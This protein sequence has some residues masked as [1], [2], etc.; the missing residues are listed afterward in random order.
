MVDVTVPGFGQSQN[1]AKCFSRF[2]GVGVA[3]EI[4]RDLGGGAKCGGGGKFHA[5]FRFRSCLTAW[6]SA[7][8]TQLM[9]TTHLPN[10]PMNECSN[11]PRLEDLCNPMPT[12]CGLPWSS[13]RAGWVLLDTL[14]R[15]QWPREQRPRV[16]GG[17]VA[18]HE[19][20]P[21]QHA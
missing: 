20:R 1:F 18:S 19:A 3:P 14:Y 16:L 6:R 12:S 11:L 13:S 10:L 8:Q 4:S 7:G 21:A 5:I 17:H 9:M 15:Y 2:G